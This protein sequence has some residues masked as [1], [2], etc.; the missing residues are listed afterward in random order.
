MLKKGLQL[1]RTLKLFALFRIYTGG[2]AGAMGADGVIGSD[3][4]LLSV[5]NSYCKQCGHCCAANCGQISVRAGRAYCR[6]HDSSGGKYPYGKKTARL[7][8]EEGLDPSEWA[9]PRPCH[10]FGPHL[11]CAEILRLEDAGDEEAAA[12]AR[13]DCPGA[14]E[15]AADYRSIFL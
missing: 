5:S 12:R 4:G 10:T 13:A 14:A 2:E 6:L 9:K 8:A 15:M 11:L 1:G 7:P 3:E